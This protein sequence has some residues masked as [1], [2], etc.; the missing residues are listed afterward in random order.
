MGGVF[1]GRLDAISGDPFDG[2]RMGLQR[3][4]VVGV[5]YLRPGS[6]VHF[7][8]SFGFGEGMLGC[9]NHIWLDTTG[10]MGGPNMFGALRCQ[11]VDSF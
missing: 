9:Q 5:Y 10:F 8:D 6:F 7:P 3:K 2:L 1:T 11:K 4:S